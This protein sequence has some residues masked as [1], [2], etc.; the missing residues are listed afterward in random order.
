MLELSKVAKS[1]QG[2]E[3]VA[4]ASLRLAA[5]QA[6]CLTGPSG[7]GK[8]T[9]LEIMA[10]LIKPDKGLARRDSPAAFMFQD[11]ALIPWLTA[12]ANIGYI[13]PPEMSGAESAR[14]ISRWL[15]RFE[16][17]GDQFPPA[18][19]GGMRRRLSLART[20]AAGRRLIILDEPFAFLDQAWQS[21]VAEE[22]MSQAGQGA[23]VVLASHSTLPFDSRPDRA[24]LEVVALERSPVTI[25]LTAG[26]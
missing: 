24:G 2:R 6:L 26:D 5:G 21:T 25:R 12:E 18:M 16:L 19:S 4:S 13:L 20:L 8:S 7:V 3:V 15:D 9:L 11:E 14:R 1:Y 23:A 22:I 17:S 10:G